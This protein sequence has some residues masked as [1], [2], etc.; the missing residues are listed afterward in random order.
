V[1]A[2]AA[3][4][5]ACG[6]DE[7]ALDS[8]PDP[9]PATSLVSAPTVGPDDGRLDRATV[10][11]GVTGCDGSWTG[12]GFLAGGGMVVTNRHVV[13]EAR[14]IT[15]TLHD[16]TRPP[17]VRVERVVTADVG[18]VTL[19]PAELPEPLSL[20]VEAAEVGD[21]VVVRGYPL[22]AGLH[23]ER[24]RVVGIDRRDGAAWPTL[25]M[26]AV[27]R[28]GSSGGPVTRSDGRVVG[29]VFALERAVDYSIAVPAAAISEALA[30]PIL[31][32]PAL[33]CTR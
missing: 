14:T 7:W 28:P 4:V 5:A 6:D 23:H 19:A 25:R 27:V 29:V 31:R 30:H 2:L 8:P 15:V 1:L 13:D 12:S 11:I 16:G 26:S 17:V 24:G 18:L 33:G 22:D 20:A 32:E 9:T 10:H 21:A 3:V